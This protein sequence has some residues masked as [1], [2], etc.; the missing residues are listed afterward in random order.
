MHKIQA[1]ALIFAFAARLLHLLCGLYIY[2]AAFVFAARLLHLPRGF[3]TLPR[4]FLTWV[5]SRPPYL[6]D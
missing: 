5:T 6:T 4:G 2:R 3:Y 1:A